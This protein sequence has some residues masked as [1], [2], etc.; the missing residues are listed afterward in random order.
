MTRDSSAKALVVRCLVRSAWFRTVVGLLGR[1]VRNRGSSLPDH[2]SL[3]AEE[4]ALGP[5]QREE[6]LL[7]FAIV[8]VARPKLVV[9][10]GFHR[11]HS[12]LN[13]LAALPPSSRLVSLDT[14]APAE[15]IARASFESDP[16]FRF[17]RRSQTEIGSVDLGDEQVDLAFFDASHDLE[18][19][20]KTFEVLL[21][22]LSP[23]AL[24][25]IHDTGSW[26]REAMTPMHVEWA[27]SHPTGE[28]AWI[29]EDEFLPW[30]AE[31]RFANWIIESRT[32]FSALHFHSDRTLRHGLTVLQRSRRL[33]AP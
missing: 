3:Y 21:P 7:L 12:A 28:G 6:A 4:S 29:S 14:A 27:R 5:I 20:R 1:L 17:I 2:L 9:E 16:R 22:R 23:G 33:E 10:F 26:R 25:V 24:V 19:N 13:F 15:S 31:R 11:G 18:I 32:E 30:P 8:R